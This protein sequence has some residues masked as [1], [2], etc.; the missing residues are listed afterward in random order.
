VG[1]GK[2]TTSAGCNVGSLTCNP[3]RVFV[4][5]VR[6]IY[7]VQFIKIFQLIMTGRDYAG[8][9]NLLITYNV[10]FSALNSFHY[11]ML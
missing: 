9:F 10:R 5:R 3:C 11:A 4:R 6:D 1:M 8:V 7:F 2:N